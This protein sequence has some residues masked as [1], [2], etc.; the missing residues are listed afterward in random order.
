MKLLA[1]G[2]LALL[3]VLFSSPANVQAV[4]V[5]GYYQSN[6]TYVSPYTRTRPNSSLYD[7]YSYSPSYSYKS[8][9]KSSY[10]PYSYKSS[11]KPYSYKSFSSRW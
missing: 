1:L 3:L 7:N 11:Y 4:S 9:Y 8:S 5:K 10:T 2:F 6:R